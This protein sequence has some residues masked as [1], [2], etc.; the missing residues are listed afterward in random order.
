MSELKE[1][2]RGELKDELNDGTDFDFGYFE[3]RQSIKRWITEDE[4][5]RQMYVKLKSGELHLWCE[6]YA[7]IE[8]QPP[9]KRKKEETNSRRQDKENLVEEAFDELQQK[10]MDTYTKPQLKLWARMLINNIHESYDQPPNVPM[11]MGTKPQQKKETLTEVIAGAAAAFVKAVKP[12]PHAQI[13]ENSRSTSPHSPGKRADARMKNFEQ[14]RYIKQLF[15]DKIL[16]EKDYI[17]QR[18]LILE[19]LRNI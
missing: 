3:G 5:L 19:A 11:I 18:G 2:L 14:L 13:S 7:D 4:D 17:E 16:E 12:V 6:L 1:K 9:P 15:E 8:N 10:H